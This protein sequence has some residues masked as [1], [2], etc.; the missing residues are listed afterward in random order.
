MTVIKYGGNA[1]KS[2]ALKEAVI[3]DL[4]ALTG[5]TVLVHGGGPEIEALLKKTGTESHFVDGLRYTDADTLDV[6]L[7]ALCGK[8]NKEL[9][10]L[11][12][13]A[14]ARAVG[15]CG[16]DGGLIRATPLRNG[17]LGFVGEVR[18]VDP[19]LLRVLLDAGML[20]VVSPVAFYKNTWTEGARHALNVNADT[21]AAAI[22]GVLQADSLILMT[23]I[24]GLLRDVHD[25]QSLIHRASAAEIEAMKE[26]GALS[27]GMIP[28]AQGCL[29]ALT[30]GVNQVRIIDGRT[31]HIL[32]R[33]LVDGE[34]CGTVIER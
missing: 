24:A 6:V 17:A 34:E 22:A 9:V 3:A 14:G 2:A 32:H 10:A 28:K 25:P 7:E 19:T 12:E 21:A 4:A 23:D 1:M 18:R 29:D 15:V 31:P 13:N 27:G 33:L 5:Q 20:P 16:I 8:V 26:S 30:W 11:L